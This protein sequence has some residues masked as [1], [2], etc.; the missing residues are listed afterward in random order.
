MCC[1]LAVDAQTPLDAPFFPVVAATDASL[2]HGAV[3][4][5]ECSIPEVAWLWSRASHKGCYSNSTFAAHLNPD[6]DLVPADEV[7]HS[8]IGGVQFKEIA[9]YK[10][11]TQQHINLL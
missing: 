8:W 5:A 4:E 9:S 11:S 6:G 2:H 7:M 1:F 3:V 10:F